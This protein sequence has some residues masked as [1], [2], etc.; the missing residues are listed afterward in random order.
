MKQTAGRDERGIDGVRVAAG[1]G[2]AGPIVDD[3]GRSRRSSGVEIIDAYL[4]VSLADPADVRGI[5]AVMAQLTSD[6]LAERVVGQDRLP[7]GRAAK[8]GQSDRDVRLG[9]DDA[10]MQRRRRLKPGAKAR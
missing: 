5:D 8:P 10:D 4:A 7:A 6:A 2:R 9:A 1:D 3:L